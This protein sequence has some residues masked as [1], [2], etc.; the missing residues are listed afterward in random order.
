[1]PDLTTQLLSELRLQRLPGL[2]LG[3][4]YVYPDYEGRSLVNVPASICRWMGAPTIGAAPLA[5]QLTENL[6]EQYQNVILIL[7]DA[8]SLTRFTKLVGNGKLPVWEKLAERGILAPLTSITPSTT[9]AALTSLWTG[10]GA[11]EHGIVGYEMWMKEYGMVINSILQAPMSF[12][13]AAGSLEKAGFDPETFIQPILLGNHL[14]AHG[15]D[16]YGFQHHSIA[17]S[18]LSRMLLQRV[19]VN[20]FRSQSDLWTNLRNVLET[21]QNERKYIWVYWGEV[22]Y[23]S[24]NYGPD[25]ERTVNELVN[26][27]NQLKSLFLDRLDQAVRGKTLLVLMADHGQIK[28]DPDPHYDLSNHPGLTRRLHIMPTGENRLAFLYLRPGQGEAAREYIE[29]T[30]P[31]QF[32]FLDPVFAVESGL[33]GPGDPHPRLFDRLGDLIVVARGN[34]YWWWS[35]HSDHLVGRH[36]GL[37]ADEML[38]PF[39]AAGL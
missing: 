2:N 36:G 31:G 10:S 26:F 33:F 23:M 37:S 39:L 20:P 29:R 30:W 4:E 17:R 24:H 1:M 35:N 21:R 34:A 13:G 18:G 14:S 28:T 5:A 32:A 3:G 9:A 6:K 11:I 16:L 25:D 12:Q 15:V 27:S 8:L 22:D 38:V 19:I 7:M